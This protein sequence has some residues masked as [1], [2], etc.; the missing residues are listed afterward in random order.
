MR[1]ETKEKDGDMKLLMY[2]SMELARKYAEAHPENSRGLSVYVQRLE[3]DM[4][5]TSDGHCHE[6]PVLVCSVDNTADLDEDDEFD[7]M[8]E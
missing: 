5:M 2:N 4:V 6:G 8:D 7:E 1:Q 3:T